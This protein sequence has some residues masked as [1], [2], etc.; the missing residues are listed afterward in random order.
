MKTK[1]VLAPG[2][3]NS[4]LPA[5]VQCMSDKAKKRLDDMA[6]E[7]IH[8]QA[9]ELAKMPPWMREFHLTGRIS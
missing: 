4:L 2:C 9:E 5:A 6:L 7:R 3:S 8:R 1:K